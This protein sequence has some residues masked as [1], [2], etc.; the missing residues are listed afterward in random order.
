[1]VMIEGTINNIDFSVPLEPDGVGSHWFRMS[2]AFC[3]EL[4]LEAGDSVTLSIRP[5]KN[6][7]EP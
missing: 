3:D 2:D 5:T 6:W 1:M 4:T 7:I